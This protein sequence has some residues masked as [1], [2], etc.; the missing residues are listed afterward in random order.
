MNWILENYQLEKGGEKYYSEGYIQQ[1]I[2]E[3]IPI[4]IVQLFDF[5]DDEFDR[6][7]ALFNEFSTFDRI[8]VYIDSHGGSL[9]VKEKLEILF[10]QYPN[11]ELISSYMLCSAAFNLFVE[12][13]CE[14]TVTEMTTPAF[15]QLTL[16]MEVNVQGKPKNE[17]SEYLNGRRDY[18][19]NYTNRI[20]D[21]CEFSAEERQ[22]IEQDKDL[23]VSPERLVEMVNNYS[24]NLNEGK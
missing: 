23:Y 2:E 4:R 19:Q 12:L 8:L 11:L 9:A 3:N 16:N 22:V 1:A 7:V 24:K 13:Q 14:K 6:I 10:S 20:M 5:T 18:F 15:H 21:M 17:L